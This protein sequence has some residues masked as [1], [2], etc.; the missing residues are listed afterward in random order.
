MFK[1]LVNKSKNTSRCRIVIRR[2]KKYSIGDIW[3]FFIKPTS[4][5]KFF[6]EAMCEND[7]IMQIDF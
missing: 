1:L 5:P 6:G 4:S 2:D 3:R 7:E